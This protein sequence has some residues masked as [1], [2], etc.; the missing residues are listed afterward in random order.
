MND[1]ADFLGPD[2]LFVFYR[3]RFQN[4]T[5]KG[6]MKQTKNMTIVTHALGRSTV[7]AATV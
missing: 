3:N 1:A 5:K 6:L 2:I 4:M 7:D